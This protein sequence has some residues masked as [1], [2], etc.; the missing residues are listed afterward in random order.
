VV[1]I[2]N[3][4]AKPRKYDKRPRSQQIVDSL[5]YDTGGVVFALWKDSTEP[6]SLGM[7]LVQGTDIGKP[8]GRGLTVGAFWCADAAEAEA[9]RQLA[10]ANRTLPPTEGRH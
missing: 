9:W 1:S 7:L 2:A 3:A 5:S 10:I 4:N 8:V 6:D